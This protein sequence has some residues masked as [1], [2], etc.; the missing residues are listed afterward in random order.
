MNHYFG[1]FIFKLTVKDTLKM[2]LTKN[3]IFNYLF[4]CWPLHKK[5]YLFNL[6]FYLSCFNLAMHIGIA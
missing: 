1:V 6:I 4:A 2:S 5:C 3:K